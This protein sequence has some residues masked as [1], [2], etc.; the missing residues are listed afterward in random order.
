MTAVNASASL[1]AQNTFTDAVTLV[2][3]F[4]VSVSGTFSATVTVQR[5]PDA[6]ST[7]YDV[8]TYTAAA[9]EVGFEAAL[10]Q[11]R[12]GIATG[13]YTSGTA[14]VAIYGNDQWRY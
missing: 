5:S 8:G 12:V 2:G 14:V 7:W 13:D 10:M 11:Y 6:G 1:T 4:S 3:D 9:E